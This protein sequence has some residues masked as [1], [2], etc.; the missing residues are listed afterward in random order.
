MPMSGYEVHEGVARNEFSPLLAQMSAASFAESQSLVVTGHSLGG[1]SASLFA[2]LM[3]DPADPLGFGGRRKMVDELYAF[4]PVPVFHGSD[5]TSLINGQSADGSFEGG[6]F[7]ALRTVD[8]EEVQDGALRL[9]AENFHF[10]KTN[11][12]NL[13]KAKAPEVIESAAVT[14]Q[15]YTSLPVDRHLFPLHNPLNY[16]NWLSHRS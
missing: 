14:K 3:N 4:G 15:T 5:Q 13:R 9:T 12:V 2:V 1:G 7:R 11:V 10:P 8:G 16:V 6:I